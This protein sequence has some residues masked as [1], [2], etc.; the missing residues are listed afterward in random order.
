MKKNKNIF[1]V[2]ISISL[3]TILSALGT[4]RKFESRIFDLLLSA[5]KSPKESPQI[6]LVEADNLA[7]ENIGA[8][9]WKRSVYANMLLRM[10]ELGAK[11]AVFDIEFLSPSDFADCDEEFARSVQFFGNTFLTINT[12]DLDI[13]YTEA[14]LNYARN[15]FLVNAEGDIN[16]IVTGNRKSIYETQ[17]DSLFGFNKIDWDSQQTKTDFSIGFSPA[18]HKFISH[19]NGAGF[20]N[21]IIDTD[22][23]RRRVEL[24]RYQDECQKSVCQ[25]VFAPLIKELA[26]EKIIRKKNSVV[27]KNCTQGGKTKDIKIP[28]DEY[29]RM[30]INWTHKK[31]QDSFRHESIL[32]MDTLDKTEQNIVL[33]LEALLENL[34][35]ILNSDTARKK[36]LSDIIS[37][38]TA[39]LLLQQYGDITDYKNYLLQI[40]DGYDENGNAVNSGIPE[41]MYAE[42]FSLRNDFFTNARNYAKGNAH[43][44]I[45]ECLLENRDLFGERQYA[46]YAGSVGELFEILLHDTNLYCDLFSEKSASYKNSF[47]IIGNTASSTTDLGTTPF[48]RAYPNIGTHANVCNTIINRDFV[49]PVNFLFGIF[50]TAILVIIQIILTE[51]KKSIIQNS[52]GIFVILIVTLTPVLLIRFCGIYVPSFTPILIAFTSYLEITILR[53]TASEKDKKFLQTTFGAYV[54]PAVVEQIVKH[55]ELAS[56]GGKSENL[57]ALFSDVKTFSGFTEVINNQYG[58]EKGAER[59]VEILNEYLGDL[60][61]AIMQNG[62]TIDKYVGDEIV[63]FFGA[64]VPRE[65]NAFD[66]CTAAV[67]MLEAEKIFNERNKDRLPVNPRTNEPFYLHSRVG[68]NTGMMV[69]GNMGT[70][71]KLNYTIMGNNVNLASRLEGTNKVYGS[72]IIASE[73]TWQ[74]A[75]SGAYEGKL[76]A[77]KFD[78]VRV[79]NV[80]KPVGIY[81]IL[82]LKEE[83]SAEQIEAAEIFNKG[84]E[85]YLNGSDTPEVKKDIAELKEAILYF[86]KAASLYPADESSNAFIERC[87]DFIKN[88]VPQIWDGVYTMQSK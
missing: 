12:A 46:E 49:T 58:E 67:R 6:L 71:K 26:P 35:D 7:L 69:V 16:S 68:L 34:N 39:A 55:P 42:Y 62:G 21:T 81:N 87:K 50:F 9:P 57:T 32:F 38:D 40:C 51:K 78:C 74:K 79:V 44:V 53:F 80:K 45:Q 70:E 30:I 3:L 56:L 63:S 17:K 52:T 10:K 28:L 33:V 20:T 54:A 15:R 24:L 48:E 41:E 83:L 72:W 29:G 88:G 66:A 76:V 18:M 77:R 25:L 37:P 11:T 2:L 75:N 73:S 47:C 43:D 19:A 14:E 60:S 8:W 84:I 4:F 31:Y 23:T 65:N 82:G 64:P 61:N 13:N 86:Q 27:L 5:K 22:G 85:L 36:N 59:L 1:I